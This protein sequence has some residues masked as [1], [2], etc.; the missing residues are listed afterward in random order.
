M[1]NQTQVNLLSDV[2]ARRHIRLR[3]SLLLQFT[4]QPAGFFQKRM[5]LNSMISALSI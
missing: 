3:D 1:L 4:L 5:E 2:K